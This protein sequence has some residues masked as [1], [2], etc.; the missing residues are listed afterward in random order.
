MPSPVVRHLV[1]SACDAIIDKLQA[2][3]PTALSDI[4]ANRADNYVTMEPPRDYFVYPKAKGYR[5]PAVFV[6]GDRIDFLKAQ[7]GANHVNAAIRVNV[8]ILVEDRDADRL[9]RK[10]YRYQ[11]AMHQVLDQVSLMTAD[12]QAKLTIVVQN[13]SFSG[14]Y[15]NMEA[16]NPAAVFRQEIALEC[17]VFDYEQL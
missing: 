6:I 1:E 8:T 14:L 7:K 17:D 13:A 2:D 9:M 4:R 16:G 10:S 3:L 15:S 5:T 11:A 12:N